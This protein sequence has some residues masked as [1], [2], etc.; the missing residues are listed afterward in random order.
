MKRI[1][2]LLLVT[3]A[4][5][6][7]AEEQIATVSFEEA[8]A[9]GKLQ[10]GTVSKDDVL[11]FR[12]GEKG[13]A[14]T[15]IE[16]PK[17]AITTPI[18]AL[19]GF[20]RYSDVAGN[21]YLQMDNHFGERGTFFTKS[22]APSGPLGAI[23]GSSDWRPFVLPF[24][25]NTGDPSAPALPAPEKLTLSLYLPA[26]GTVELRNVSLF[27]YAAGENPLPQGGNAGSGRMLGLIGGIGGGV[28]GLWGAAI[29]TLSGLGR[30]RSFVM[31]SMNLFGILGAASMIAGIGGLVMG[32][33]SQLIWVLIVVGVV[34]LAMLGMRH[35]IRA[36]YEEQELR[37]M[38]SVD[39]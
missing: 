14:A 9:A 17:P 36:R 37:R 22:L 39:A 23:S 2:V 20:I 29:G 7:C 34:M 35:T 25:A 10:N 18:Y 21:G 5:T 8:Q 28:I 30:G 15:V 32:Q 11:L 38:R 33:R 24:F 27:Q 16:L 12:A 19:R 31:T 6:V 13:I 3:C 4:S 26:S 1:L